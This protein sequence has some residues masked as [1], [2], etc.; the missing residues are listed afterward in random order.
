MKKTKLLEPLLGDWNNP[1]V[2]NL[3]KGEES[4]KFLD[5]DRTLKINWK[6][7]HSYVPEFL[8]SDNR[9]KIIDIASGNGA[10]MEIFR[11]Y[12][13]ECYGMDYT[14]NFEK[15]DWLY[16]PLLKSQ[17]LR[18]KVHDG[19]L[20]PYPFEDKEADLVICFGAITF[21]K[22]TEIWPQVMDEFA[23]IA[24]EGILVGVN[25][26]KVFDEGERHLDNWTHPEFKLEWKQG[27]IY[28]W[29]RK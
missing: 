23:R 26:G 25:V 3:F 29:V 24:K 27:S 14:P 8:L 17:N 5:R 10:T 21:F 6:R 13:H 2:K 16:K 12:G 1:D 7:L 28:K 9:L 4:H 19:S 20:L 15:D 22:P 18:C 11:Y